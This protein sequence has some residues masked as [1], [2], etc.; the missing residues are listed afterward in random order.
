MGEATEGR[1]CAGCGKT[2]RCDNES[3]YCG[4]CWPKS[5]EKKTAN[6]EWNAAH[7][8]YRVAYNRKY[9][10]AHYSPATVSPPCGVCGKKLNASSRS[11]LCALCWRKTPEGRA[12]LGDNR[13]RWD[14][15]RMATPDAKIEYLVRFA[16]GRAKRAGL[17]HGMTVPDLLPLPAVCPV[18]GIAL[19]YARGPRR[20]G[21]AS[22][23]RINPSLGY[24]AGNVRIISW[25]AN[26]LKKDGTPDELYAVAMDAMRVAKRIV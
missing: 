5:P 12:M 8:E 2:L 19:D 15:E 20:A 11:G 18:L 9:H 6:Q 16:N 24:V 10:R 25:R 3:G 23:D 7:P 14:R 17:S 4:K 21:S 13:N 22:I 1:V 26:S